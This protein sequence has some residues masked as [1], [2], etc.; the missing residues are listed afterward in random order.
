MNEADWNFEE[1]KEETTFTCVE[2][3][4]TQGI[5]ADT[6]ITLDLFFLPIE[7]EEP[8]RE[9]FEKALEA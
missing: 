6:I 4:D 5:K 1:Q 8:K 9:A 3:R 2:L 7:G